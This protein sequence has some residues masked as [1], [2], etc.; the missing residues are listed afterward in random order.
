M[1]INGENLLGYRQTRYEQAVLPPYGK[2]VFRALWVLVK[3]QAL[4]LALNWRFGATGF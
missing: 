3:G 4:S 2:P 1:I